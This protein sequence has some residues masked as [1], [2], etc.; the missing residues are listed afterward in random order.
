MT[1]L[2]LWDAAM[3]CVGVFVTCNAGGLALCA[4]WGR[5]TRRAAP[6]KAPKAAEPGDEPRA[7][8]YGTELVKERKPFVP[9][10]FEEIRREVDAFRKD[11]PKADAEPSGKADSGGRR[12]TPEELAEAYRHSAA[13]SGKADGAKPFSREELSASA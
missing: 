7:V 10:T 1:T 9:Q 5:L 8:A 3:Y 6:G 4:A 13:A 12:V 2:E 11:E